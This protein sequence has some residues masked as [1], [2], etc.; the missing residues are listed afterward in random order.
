MN[1]V[2]D[3]SHL[4]KE[5]QDA[6]LK[7]M[8]R[9]SNEL[10]PSQLSQ[11]SNNISPSSSAAQKS[12]APTRDINN[13]GQ[14]QTH[15]AK[16]NQP[17]PAQASKPMEVPAPVAVSQPAPASSGQPQ[18]SA[19]AGAALPPA[20]RNSTPQLA[21]QTSAQ[22]RPIRSLD[23]NS[24]AV[25]YQASLQTNGGHS[26]NKHLRSG[27][28]QSDRPPLGL[29]PGSGH[30][31]IPGTASTSLSVLNLAKNAMVS[32]SN[33]VGHCAHSLA[34]TG[35]FA[36]SAVESVGAT[37]VGV[38]GVLSKSGSHLSGSSNELEG[39][40]ARRLCSICEK[41]TLISNSGNCCKFCG[42]RF[43]SRCTFSVPVINL[44]KGA[45]LRGPRDSVRPQPSHVNVSLS[46]SM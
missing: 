29:A 27:S 45:D 24:S 34:A 7:V 1:D 13:N 33:V 12:P 8:L 20:Q 26:Q 22:K 46:S 10:T 25:G 43:C 3:L 2:P 17:A 37:A 16:L 18:S 9:A 38:G 23:R 40:S 42:K 41:V 11:P 5:E 14:A 39:N 36:A 35:S 31:S 4:T 6:I 21:S 19:G 32:T 44:N 15:P 30:S 28:A